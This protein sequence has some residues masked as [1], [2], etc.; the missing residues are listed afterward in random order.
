MRWNAAKLAFAMM[1][2]LGGCA[3]HHYYAAGGADVWSDNETV[4]YNQ[5]EVEGH[6][7]HMEYERRNADEQHAYWSWR[8]EHQHD[9][10]H[11]NDH[12]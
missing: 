1:V 11:D 3:T 5:W 4:Y 9:H 12:H 7:P 8:H 2:G 10:D 6:R